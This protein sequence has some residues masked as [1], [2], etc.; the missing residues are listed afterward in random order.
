MTQAELDNIGFQ[1]R[2]ATLGRAIKGA[3]NQKRPA[4]SAV[5]AASAVVSRV[6]GN[7]KP[8]TIQANKPISAKRWDV[9][10]FTYSP[11]VD[12]E[13]KLA[14][15]WASSMKALGYEVLHRS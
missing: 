1:L 8:A 11:A 12:D 7:R 2:M 5:V 6:M 10:T 4:V 9:Q 14:C 3:A 15:A 13:T